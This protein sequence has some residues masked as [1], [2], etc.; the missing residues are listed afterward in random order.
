[1]SFVIKFFAIF[2]C[3]ITSFI[4]IFYVAIT[5]ITAFVTGNL[6]IQIVIFILLTVILIAVFAG[7]LF[8]KKLNAV[9]NVF[10]FFIF[11][12]QC[13]FIKYSLFI[14]TVNKIINIQYCL[15]KGYA[16]DEVKNECN[17]NVY[18]Y[19]FNSNKK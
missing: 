12:L 16:W 5:T 13:L 10:I 8:C 15:D 6:D 11:L 14:P 2:L 7:I 3:S 1:M 9:K 19:F 17:K 18:K 4:L